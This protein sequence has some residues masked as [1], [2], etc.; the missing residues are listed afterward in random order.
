M[1]G[2]PDRVFQSIADVTSGATWPPAVRGASRDDSGPIDEGSRFRLSTRGLGDQIVDVVRFE[3]I[4]A[5]SLRTESTL[6]GIVHAY[7]IEATG[8]GKTVVNHEVTVS[9]RRLSRL[10]APVLYV[11]L[12][13]GVRLEA[14]A[15]NRYFGRKA[16]P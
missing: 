5:V 16:S 10:V 9:F 15:L 6:F 3:P 14:R 4:S 13:T 7:R 2:A 12:W 8:G 1:D 11:A